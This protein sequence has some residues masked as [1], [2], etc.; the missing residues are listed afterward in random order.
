[1]GKYLL[2]IYD[3]KQQ[4]EILEEMKLMALENNWPHVAKAFSKTIVSANP[5]SVR[6]F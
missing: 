1:M 3:D 4:K 5:A 6:L 2:K